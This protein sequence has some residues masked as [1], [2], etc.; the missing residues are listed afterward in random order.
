VRLPFKKP[1]N[2]IFMASLSI[3]HFW[4][5]FKKHHHEFL[6]PDTKSKD[7]IDYWTKELDTLLHKYHKSLNFI[8]EWENEMATLT[9]SAGGNRKFFKQVD[10]LIDEAPEIPGWMYNA[11]M[12]PGRIDYV[13]D[14][15]TKAADVD[16][17]EFRFS[18]LKPKNNRAELVV[19]H[20]S[21]TP[22]NDIPIFELVDQIVFNM[23]G[24]RSF[25]YNINTIDVTHIS[26][27]E[28]D[29]LEKLEIL[30]VL[31]N[32]GL[33]VSSDGSLVRMKIRK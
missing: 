8:I 31:F 23:L 26:N 1:L 5:W 15:L 6:E 2:Q 9:I 29:K 13:V 11:L 7:D 18:F 10:D 3:N 19:F 16:P 24:E 28:P 27:S 30:P 21:Y 14:N 12:P 22:E 32:A 4:E 17:K 20:P 25:G 33:M